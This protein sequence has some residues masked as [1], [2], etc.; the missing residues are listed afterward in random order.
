MLIQRRRSAAATWSQRLA[1]FALPFFVVVIAG[2]RFGQI[3]TPVV[4]WL[5]AIGL[6]LL[7]ASLFAAAVGFY[8]LWST[9]AKGGLN[10]VRGSLLSIIVLAPFVWFGWKAVTLPTLHDVSTDLDDPPEFSAAGEQRTPAMNSLALL[11]A[12]SVR[13]QLEAYPQVRSRRYQAPVD[14]VFKAVADIIA[15][16][17]WTV[18][19]EDELDTS[20]RIDIPGT[21]QDADP[22]TFA[23]GK[24][25]RVILPAFRPSEAEIREILAAGQNAD[26]DDDSDEGEVYVEA[27]SRSLLFGFPSDIVIRLVQEDDGTLVDMRSSSRW[28]PHDLGTNAER[29]ADFLNDLDAALIGVAGEQ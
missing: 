12:T 8:Q 14:R 28:G 26:P 9:A 10:C 13:A 25:K 29:I 3:P 20:G 24:L 15:A 27:M 22:N 11:D 6:S 16:R 2:H 1:V 7:C 17:G 19:A 5:I 23:D 21:A 18:T 4:F